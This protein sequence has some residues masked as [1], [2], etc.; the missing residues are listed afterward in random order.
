MDGNA[1]QARD[2]MQQFSDMLSDAQETLKR[3]AQ[4]S[5]ER[6]RDLQNQVQAKLREA[7]AYASQLQTDA[8]ESARAAA[9]ATDEYVHENPWPAIGVAVVAGFLAGLLVTRR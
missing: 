2:R 7:S 3:A 4:E 1:E 5:G 6:A 9:A 8:V